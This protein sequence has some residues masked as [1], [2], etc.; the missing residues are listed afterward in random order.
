LFQTPR[1]IHCITTHSQLQALNILLVHGMLRNKWKN[2]ASRE[3]QKWLREPA[4][5][6]CR[7]RGV[8]MPFSY[9]QTLVEGSLYSS[10]VK[11]RVGCPTAAHGRP[12]SSSS[13][14]FTELRGHGCRAMASRLESAWQ[15]C[16][17]TSLFRVSVASLPSLIPLLASPSPS[18]LFTGEAVCFLTRPVLLWKSSFILRFGRR[19]LISAAL[20]I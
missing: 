6:R 3:S 15:L 16:W 12:G 11:C 13:H 18:S 20:L 2:V 5:A 17:F 19:S 14:T 10:P 4:L 7:E 8:G 9:L 1:G